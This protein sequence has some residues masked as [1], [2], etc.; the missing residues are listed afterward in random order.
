MAAALRIREMKDSSSS[1]Q[2]EVTM[3]GPA[4]VGRN[5]AEYRDRLHAESARVGMDPFRLEGE[6][7]AD[8]TIF[9]F[10]EQMVE[11]QGALTNVGMDR[12]YL[13]WLDLRDLHGLK[14]M[15]DCLRHA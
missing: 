8:G 1:R 7:Q 5:E 10:G 11:R 15:L 3:K 9:G 12:Y 6:W 13:Q 4:V 14:D 2:V